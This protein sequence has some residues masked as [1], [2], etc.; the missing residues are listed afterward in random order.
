MVE[1]SVALNDIFHA[2]ADPTR[3]AIVARLAA[4]PRTVGHLSTPFPMSLAA[5]SKH[6]KVLE[7]AQLVHR[8]VRGR[9]HVLSL[10][11]A[12]LREAGEWLRYHEQFWNE[13]LDALQALLTKPRARQSRKRKAK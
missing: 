6:L 1:H 10:D 8:E 3:R 9:E 5:V 13:R 4:G 12:G 11:P 7:R 2:L